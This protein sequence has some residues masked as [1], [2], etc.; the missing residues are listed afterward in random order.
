MGCN[1]QGLGGMH[2]AGIL[3]HQEGFKLN[4]KEL[5]GKIQTQIYHLCLQYYLCPANWAKRQSP[6]KEGQQL[7]LFTPGW[8]LFQWL[9][10]CLSSDTL[11]I[12][13][14]NTY[15]L[16][17]LVFWMQDGLTFYLK[18]SQCRRSLGLNQDYGGGLKRV[19]NPLPLHNP[20]QVQYMCVCK[21]N[22][23]WDDGKSR[24]KSPIHC[25]SYF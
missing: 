3:S 21:R 7:S 9:F 19:L 25:P 20:N 14:G 15:E 5:S 23:N 12:D 8:Y 2:L 13:I 1:S 6:L 10:T 11:C 24:I 17:M 22:L 16:K 4:A 18:N